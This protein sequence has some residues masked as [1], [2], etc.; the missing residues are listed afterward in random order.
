VR[1]AFALRASADSLRE[2]PER[3]LVTL[4]FASW[5]RIAP[6]LR[7]LNTLLNVQSRRRIETKSPTRRQPGCE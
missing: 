5:N 1:S 4:T 3:K 6:W 2:R 7:R